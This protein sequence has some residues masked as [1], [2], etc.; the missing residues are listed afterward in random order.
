MKLQLKSTLKRNVLIFDLKALSSQ[1]VRKLTGM[2][3][4]IL[5][6]ACEKALVTIGFKV[7][8]GLNKESFIC[9]AHS[10]C[11]SVHH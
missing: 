6:A 5:G 7:I 11:W 9:R 8:I 4:D 1:H 3:F 10:S 2:E